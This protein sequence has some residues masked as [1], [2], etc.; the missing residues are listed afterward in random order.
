MAEAGNAQIDYTQKLWGELQTLADASGKVKDSDKARADFIIGELNSALDTEYSMTGNIINN[1]KEM[2]TSIEKVIETKRAQILLEAYEKS[3]SDAVK[4]VAA[5]ENERAIKAQELSLIEQEVAAKRQEIATQEAL[6][7]Q[8]YDERTRLMY[9]QQLTRMEGE[10]STLEKTLDKK[11]TKFEESDKTLKGYYDNINS[12]ETASTLVLEGET[13]KAINY[14][15]RFGGGFKTAASVAGK[16]KDEQLEILRDQVVNTE[17]HL[18]LLEAEFKEKQSTMT[19]EE[20]RQAKLRIENAKKQAT[21]AKNEYYKVGGNMVE[22]MAKGAE[23][24]EWTLTGSLKKTVAA[25]LK[26]A[27]KA[28]GIKSPSRV[29]R[30]EVGKQIPAGAALGVTDGTPS[31]V[32]AIKKQVN[33]IKSAYDLSGISETVGAGAN[34]TAPTKTEQ[35]GGVTVYQTNK[36]KQAYTSPIE[37]YKAKQELFAVARMIK[38]GAI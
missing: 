31:V 18:G 13:D 24:N 2:V 32:K 8:T 10:L 28:L 7:A 17:I 22:G 33:A 16:S 20:K 21:D 38:A 36:Y 29:F 6:I 11:T 23:E 15:N 5:A 27:K 34:K 25:G 4:N 12:Y 19:E 37:K 3:Y 35:Q 14:L 26:A 1:Y 9:D 30:K